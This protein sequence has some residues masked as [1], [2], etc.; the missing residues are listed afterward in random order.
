MA[1]W[2]SLQWLNAT[3]VLQPFVQNRITELR[4]AQYITVRHVPSSD[5]PA[6]FATRGKT[7]AIL[8]T[9]DLWWKGPEWL[10][11]ERLW[12]SPPQNVSIYENPKTF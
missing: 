3:E 1:F 10:V 9:L 12:P 5:N 2:N 11:H 7:L 4:R 8:T 6:D